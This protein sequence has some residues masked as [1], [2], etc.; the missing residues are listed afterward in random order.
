M[1][2]VTGKGYRFV[3]RIDFQGGNGAVSNGDHAEPHLAEEL[4]V[5]ASPKVTGRK[6]SSYVVAIAVL[7]KIMVCPYRKL[8]LS[9]IR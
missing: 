5:N 6:T 9:K 4:R 8:D 2:T 7:L 1:Q 3:G